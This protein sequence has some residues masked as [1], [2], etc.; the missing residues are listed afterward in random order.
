MSFL[1]DIFL[2]IE[3]EFEGQTKKDHLSAY[4]TILNY[5][6]MD[7][8]GSGLQALAIQERFNQQQEF[9]RVVQKL[10]KHSVLEKSQ[11]GSYN[12]NFKAKKSI[13]SIFNE[14]IAMMYNQN[15]VATTTDPVLKQLYSYQAK[16]FDSLKSFYP[17]MIE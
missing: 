3:T 16:K 6:A 9:E 5:L 10:L 12:L 4:Y 7:D 13:N 17:N 15:K 14:L 1:N 2:E 11:N 8:T